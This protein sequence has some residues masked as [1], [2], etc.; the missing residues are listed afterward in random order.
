MVVPFYPIGD[1][2]LKAIIRLQLK[3]IEKRVG[4]NHNV[5]FTYDDAIVDLI[6][7]R[8]TEVES[9][10]RMVDALLT[11]NLLPA[12]SSEFLTRIMEGKKISKVHVGAEKEAFSYKFD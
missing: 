9:G 7:A 5:P 6:A 12:I 3:R 4:E 1:E 2:T 8:C 10:A 11:H